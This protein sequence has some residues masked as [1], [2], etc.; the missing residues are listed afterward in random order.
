MNDSDPV[1]I[2]LTKLSKPSHVKGSKKIFWK[3][4]KKNSSCLHE[5]W[6]YGSGSG[7]F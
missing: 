7:H 4:I 5:K 3:I 1:D 6:K 2:E